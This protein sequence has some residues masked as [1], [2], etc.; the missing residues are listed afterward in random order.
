MK[1]FFLLKLPKDLN[2]FLEYQELYERHYLKIIAWLGLPLIATL[3]FYNIYSSRYMETGFTFILFLIL[4]IFLKVLNSNDSKQT[5]SKKTVFISRVVMVLF[6]LFLIYTIGVTQSISKTP[7]TMV[8]PIFLFFSTRPKEKLFWIVIVGILLIYFILSAKLNPS[9]AELFEFKTKILIAYSILTMVALLASAIVQ[10][11]IK[12]LFNNQNELLKKNQALKQEIAD[13]A[14]ADIALVKSERK[15]RELVESIYEVIYSMDSKGIIT[16]ISPPIALIMGYKPA[17]IIGT[18]FV[19]YIHEDDL[20]RIISALEKLKD[21]KIKPSEYRVKTK[22]GEYRW[23]RSL[24]RA[25]K[26]LDGDDDIQG[27]IIDIDEQKQIYESLKKNEKQLQTIFENAG[28][29]ILV[30]INSDKKIVQSNKKMRD[31]LGYS[32][33]EIKELSIFDINSQKRFADAIEQYVKM[34]KQE[35]ILSTIVPIEKKDGT[36]FYADI[37]SSLIELENKECLMGI[38]RDVSK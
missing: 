34:G 37:S 24:S 11:V 36:V 1:N 16:Y 25:A 14:I 12:N 22:S 20:E 26:K 28:D 8:L 15:Y 30:I 27:L 17:E 18:P 33:N 38:F 32:Q 19:Q 13:R 9:A 4:C 29:G 10:S 21:G 5:I 6:I 3:F 31:L 2:N 7:L 35:V 23:I